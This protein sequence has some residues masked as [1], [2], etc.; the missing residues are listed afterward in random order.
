MIGVLFVL[1]SLAL[2]GPAQAGD[3]AVGTHAASGEGSLSA[4]IDK[5]IRGECR[6]SLDDAT[7]KR[8]EAFTP[9]TPSV[10]RVLIP[11]SAVIAILQ[12]LPLLHAVNGETLVIAAAGSATVQISGKTYS[13][14]GP[15]IAISGSDG[16]VI[17][18]GLGFHGFPLTAIKMAGRDN[19]LIDVTVSASGTASSPAVRILGNH[20][21]VASSAFHHNTGDGIGVE[22]GL[23]IAD[24][25]STPQGL[26][27]RLVQNTIAENGGAG[28]R[29][30]APQVI[31][32]ENNIHHNVGAG[33]VVSGIPGVAGCTETQSTPYT[34]ELRK[35][36]ITG[37]A[38]GIVISKDAL[39]PPVDLV[40]IGSPTATAYHVTGMIG[41]NTTAGYPWDDAHLNLKGAIVDI[42]LSDDAKTRQGAVYLASTTV[43]DVKSRLFSAHIPKPLVVDGKKISNPVFVALVTDPEHH[44]TSRFSDPLDVALTADWDHDGIPNAQEDL[45]QD[46]MV[47]LVT[48]ETDPR[49]PDSDGDGLTDGEERLHTG[50]VATAKIAFK[51]LNRLNPASS[52]SDDDC[53]PDGLELGV[54]AFE[55]PQPAKAE[56]SILSSPSPRFSDGCLELLKTHKLYQTDLSDPEKNI[57]LIKNILM[58]DPG[59]PAIPSNLVGV[60]DTDPSSQ[61]DP[62]NKDTDG[63]YL[64]DGAE[65]WNWDGVRNKKDTVWLEADPN[66]KDSDADGLPDGDEDKNGTSPLL[67]D[68]DRDGVPDA[69][70]LRQG[71]NPTA[72]DSDADGLPDGIENNLSNIEAPK[73][74]PGAPLGGSNFATPSVLSSSKKDSDGD[75]LNDGDE[76]KN[77]NGWLDPDES[78][79]TAADTDG[80]GLRDDVEMIGDI[81]HDG[82]PDFFVG[83]I[84]GGAKCTPPQSIADVDCDGLS[85]AQD[86]DSDNDGCPDGKEGVEAGNNPHGIPA[87]FNREAKQCG[88]NG[89]GSGASGSGGVTAGG[90][91]KTE[92]HEEAAWNAFWAGRTDGGGDCSL[93]RDSSPQTAPISLFFLVALT[94]CVL[95]TARTARKKNSHAPYLKCGAGSG[96]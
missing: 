33:V 5:A 38:D 29:V 37:N 83:D 88:A 62:T 45:N 30:H 52:D 10:Q 7:R 15:P 8:Y 86:T 48:F 23:G 51:D 65:D 80:D 31:A 85:N 28:L 25:N 49:L 92:A 69:L 27:T 64:M 70:E 90:S 50:R 95:V 32:T 24:C 16:N 74:C 14:T 66:Q 3:C 4:I 75:G 2:A 53:L 9:V 43:L 60:Y 61:T 41:R 81:D 40:D 93:L 19:L 78:D 77:H 71:A 79:P 47:S 67:S 73:D 44:N 13:A 17:L 20:N 94:G 72:C 91:A 55:W 89:P 76:D 22:D 57:L 84:T 1:I 63:D 58:R 34:A 68:S 82:S 46:G 96:L 21:V 54:A 11:K 87:A 39:V 56:Y 12:P 6:V 26:M 59:R 42:F 35:N 18:D 36:R